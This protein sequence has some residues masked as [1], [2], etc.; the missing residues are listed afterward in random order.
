MPRYAHEEI[1]PRKAVKAGKRA[2]RAGGKDQGGQASFGL[3]RAS[4]V[5]RHFEAC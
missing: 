4:C 5:H 2:K 1:L 3:A